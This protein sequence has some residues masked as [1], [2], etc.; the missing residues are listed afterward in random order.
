M[1]GYDKDTI[2]ASLRTIAERLG[3]PPTMTEYDEWRTREHPSS[4]TVQNHYPGWY[5]AL[6]DAGLDP[7]ETL[8]PTTLEGEPPMEDGTDVQ[9]E[10]RYSAELALLKHKDGRWRAMLGGLEGTPQAT[11]DDAVNDVWDR[12]KEQR[13]PQTE[14][15]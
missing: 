7:E 6:R 3:K 8:A 4:D 9:F 2:R 13:I 11:I 12:W 10:T 5:D 14:I 1:K 15:E